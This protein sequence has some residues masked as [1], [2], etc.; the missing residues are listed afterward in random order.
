MSNNTYFS[1]V[2]VKRNL[3]YTNFWYWCM[4][5]YKLSIE[6]EIQTFQEHD[7]HTLEELKTELMQFM[8]QKLDEFRLERVNSLPS[9]KIG[10]ISL[11]KES[12]T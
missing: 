1:N 8:S 9:G 4:P 6:G 12:E 3:Y 11:T 5:L 10:N 2:I 7:E